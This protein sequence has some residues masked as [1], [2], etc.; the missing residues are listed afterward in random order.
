MAVYR[1]LRELRA[2]DQPRPLAV[3]GARELAGVLRRE[4]SRGAAP[5]SVVEAVAPSDTAALVYVLAG[6]PAAD[7]ERILRE[8]ARARL[9]VVAVLADP[10]ADAKV[11]HVVA[12]DVVRVPPGSGFPLEEITAALAPR[13]GDDGAGLAARVPALRRA[14]CEA[15][16]TRVARQNGIIGAAVFLPGADLPALTLNQLRLVLTIAAA[17]GYEVDAQR[18]PEILGVIGGGLGFR[19]VAR[20]L[21]A[22]VPVAGW[23]VKGAVA[24]A[25]TRALGEAAIRYFEA[26]ASTQQPPASVSRDAS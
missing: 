6:P 17:Y 12:T 1:L 13:L 4:L 22:V 21:L 23:A 14:F 8:A 15:L 5:G 11:P 25:G 20:Q 10:A 2:S 7:D 24:Y 18:W 19:A 9:P 3:G 16:V 26:R